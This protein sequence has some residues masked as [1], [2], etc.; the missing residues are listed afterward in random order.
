MAVLQDISQG[1]G[2][3]PLV[4]LSAK[5][6]GA[7]QAEVLLKIESM[8]PLGSVK[9]RIG[10]SMV[11]DAESRGQ[12]KAGKTTL[13][14]P[15]SGNTG[16]A[17]AFVAAARGYKLILT[18]PETMS[19][20]RRRMLSVLGAELV[21]TPGSEGMKG[22]VARAESLVKELPEAYMLQQ[23][24]NPANP[25]AHYRTTG[26][27]IWQACQG[28]IDI[29]V[30]GV[31]TGG[32]ISG[33]GR[34]L[35][36]QNPQIK[37]V[38][39]EPMDSPV[40]SQ[41]L[42]GQEIK[43]GPHKIQGIGAG[44]IPGILDLSIIDTVLH[45]TNDQAFAMGRLLPQREGILAGISSGANVHAAIELARLPENSGKTIVTIACSTGERYLSTALFE[46]N[47]ASI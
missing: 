10:I 3:T 13:V 46:S 26:P 4:R 18:M 8:N 28:K 38:A 32:T 20:E 35:K 27:E 43:P 39:V 47:E 11:L 21:L 23:F 7:V 33:A 12:I 19:L 40:I 41:K 16:I 6:T 31:G 15:T 9:D 25:L 17:L 29:F 36:E 24:A 42:A 22:A 5:I 2:N 45:V 34:Y 1:V 30:A 44:F 14:E 37:I